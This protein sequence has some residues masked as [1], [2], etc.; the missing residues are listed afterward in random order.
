MQRP[1][2]GIYQCGFAEAW[3]AFEQ[4]MAA[5]DDGTE[6]LLNDVLLTDD[7]FGNFGTELLKGF[8][9]VNNGGGGV[10]HEMVNVVMS[11]T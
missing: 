8:L 4:H 6:H 2:Q 9:E 10:G 5:A 7:E 11:E 1:G 3:N